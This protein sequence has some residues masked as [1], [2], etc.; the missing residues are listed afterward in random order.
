MLLDIFPESIHAELSSIAERHGP[1]ALSRIYQFFEDPRAD[2]AP[3]QNASYVFPGISKTP[4]HELANYDR[5]GEIAQRLES[6]FAKVK[7]EFKCRSQAWVPYN[8]ANGDP[9]SGWKALYLF[10]S[11]QIVTENIEHFKET[12]ACLQ[13]DKGNP[14][15][16]LYSLA[17]VHFSILEPG[18]Y[19]APHTDLCNF[20][21][22]FHLAIDIPPDCGIRVANETRTW[23]EGKCLLF[24]Y[25]FVHDAW[26]KSDRTRA[27]LL[28]DVWH[29]EVTLP[30]RQALQ[31]VFKWLYE[32]ANE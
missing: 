1:N 8:T 11:G 13:C 14:A 28:M 9:V 23:E 31:L 21:L 3:L 32:Q 19:I 12:L 25:S 22:S 27:V 24:D 29:P 30:E 7:E 2:K 5:L 16:Y 6:N 17:E 26:N 20:T 4:W 15:D 10:K 18:A